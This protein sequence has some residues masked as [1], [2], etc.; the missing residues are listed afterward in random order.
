MTAPLRPMDLGEILDRTFQIYRSKFLVFLGIAAIPAVALPVFL[1]AGYLLEAVT[2][3]STLPAAGTA[4]REIGEWITAAQLESLVRCLTWPALVYIA[5]RALL[6]EK[7]TILSAGFWCAARWRSC[8]ALATILFAVWDLLPGIM[9]RLAARGHAG[10]SLG[11]TFL[12]AGNAWSLQLGALL[13]Y[14]A[15]FAVH[16]S[17]SVALSPI[18]PPYTLERL[19]IRSAFRRGWGLANGSRLRIFAAWTMA[20]VLMWVLYVA[21]SS[22]AVLILGLVFHSP[23]RLCYGTSYRVILPILAQ[24]ILVLVAPLYPIAVTLIYYDQRIRK[25]GYDIERMMDAAG[26]N[27]PATSPAGVG[28]SA[29]GEPA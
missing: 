7:P 23:G 2:S 25:E 19:S 22:L 18:V 13:M 27:A 20:A 10:A 11:S 29:P 5:S 6:G 21:F 28:R 8:L 12:G 17:L 15:Y 1:L 9:D 4:F 24:A 16:S 14:L 3:Q 26:L